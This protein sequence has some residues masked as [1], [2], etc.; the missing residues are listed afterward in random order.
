MSLAY[1]IK[2]CGRKWLS[3]ALIASSLLSTPNIAQCI[4]NAVDESKPK[5]EESAQKT[6]KEKRS[7]KLNLGFLANELATGGSF[8][9][10]SDDGNDDSWK[11]YFTLSYDYAAL[12]DKYNFLL[13][14][15]R[16]GKEKRSLNAGYHMTYNKKPFLDIVFSSDGY[17]NI[18]S[19]FLCGG[20]G[21][22]FST[23]ILNGLKIEGG[24]G[25]KTGKFDSKTNNTYNVI[26]ALFEYKTPSN[27]KEYKLDTIFRFYLPSQYLSGDFIEGLIIDG[28]AIFSINQKIF[29]VN[30]AIGIGIKK[31]NI[32]LGK[33]SYA[34]VIRYNVTVGFN[35]ES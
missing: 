13:K 7:Y 26:N 17:V 11:D 28:K 20:L 33:G 21:K 18:Y 3:T 31:D 35:L 5:T 16:A 6:A 4:D 25:L 9:F 34:E 10:R 22:Q 1:R 8:S 23:G 15:E 19:T 14:K 30:P 29:G 12:N 24:A 2:G 27:T 32:I